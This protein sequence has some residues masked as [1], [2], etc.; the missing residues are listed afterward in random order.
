MGTERCVNATTWEQQVGTPLLGKRGIASCQ[1]GNGIFADKSV[2][3]GFWAEKQPI[4]HIR[5][6]PTLVWNG[7]YHFRAHI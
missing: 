4:E 3:L 5:V 7:T 2:V 1:I 6:G